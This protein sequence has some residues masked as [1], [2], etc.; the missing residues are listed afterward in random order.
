MSMYNLLE[1]SQNYSITAGSLW[2]SYKG[3]IDDVVDNASDGKS[4]KYKTKIVVK[5]PERPTWTGNPGD[6][7]QPPQPAV[8]TLNVEVPI[9]LK[10]FINFWR[11]LDL[12]LVNCEVE[13]D[14]LWTK[15]CVLIIHHNNITWV[16]FM[17]TSTK[18]Y[19]PVVTLSTND[20]IKVFEN[21]NK[22]LKEQ[23]LGTN[24]DLK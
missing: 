13:L 5:T 11:F 24:I 23:F 4:F 16:Y 19:V 12:L 9:S 14:L 2:N 20:D 21:T 22:D 10:Y 1:Y 6:V 15:D 3:K 8:P 7:N 17:I 18:L